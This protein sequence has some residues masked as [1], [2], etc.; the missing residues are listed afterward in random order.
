MEHL[1]G[2]HRALRFLAR[3]LGRTWAVPG[4]AL[5]GGRTSMLQMAAMGDAVRS[6]L[7][8]YLPGHMQLDAVNCAPGLQVHLKE[9]ILTFFFSTRM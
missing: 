9:H 6:R 2:P 5:D 8:Q 1:A 7:V 4:P 3:S